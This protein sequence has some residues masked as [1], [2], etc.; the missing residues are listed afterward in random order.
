MIERCVIEFSAPEK[1]HAIVLQIKELY[2]S[3]GSK[4]LFF[5]QCARMTVLSLS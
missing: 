3:P 4:K 2:E 5:C 1:A